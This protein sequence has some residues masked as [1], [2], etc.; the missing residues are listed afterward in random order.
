MKFNECE[1]LLPTDA[2]T[3]YCDAL[4][5]LSEIRAEIMDEYRAGRLMLGEAS[6]A[7]ACLRREVKKHADAGSGVY[8]VLMKYDRDGDNALHVWKT[9]RPGEG[10]KTMIEAEA[11]ERARKW[12]SPED[13]LEYY[14]EQY[15]ISPKRCEIKFLPFDDENGKYDTGYRLELRV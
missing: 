11:Q 1:R 4:L 13:A 7:I 6:D 2:L 5:K 3:R 9:G 14:C 10:Y 8:D 15:G 12:K